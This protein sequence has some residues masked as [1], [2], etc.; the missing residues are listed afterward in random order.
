MPR[1]PARAISGTDISPQARG[2]LEPLREGIG[3]SDPHRHG[4]SSQFTATH[5]QA[6]NRPPFTGGLLF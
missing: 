2:E 3:A 5:L 1:P 6:I 4:Q